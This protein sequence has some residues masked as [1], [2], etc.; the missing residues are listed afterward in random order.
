MVPLRRATAEN[1]THAVTQHLIYRHGCPTTLVSDNGTQF[2]SQR[3]K[4]LL[5]AFGIAHRKSPVYAP[6]CNPVERANRTVKTMIAQYVGKQHRNWDERI[7]ALQFAINTARHEATGYTPAYIIHGRELARPHPEDR[8]PPAPAPSPD[9]NRK[10]LEEAFEVVRI[11]LARA[12]QRQERHYNLRR[13]DWRPQIGEQV[14]KR[15]RPLSSKS[16][17]FNAKLA[18]R[19]I[20]PLEVR[21][22]VSPVMVDLRDARGK[23][24]RH[25]HVQDLK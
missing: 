25:I 13:R 4:T 12:F 18:P 1:L 20:G 10:R 2:P 8:R 14:W 7:V 5:A 22:I 6:Q 23:W 21:K 19:Y 16:G 3:F 9:V 15:D 11:H 24:H 17:A